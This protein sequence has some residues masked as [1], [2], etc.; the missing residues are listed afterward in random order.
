MSRSI[1]ISG[2]Y[3]N[4][5][6]NTMSKKISGQL[7]EDFLIHV[8]DLEILPNDGMYKHYKIIGHC[9]EEKILNVTMIKPNISMIRNAVR[10]I[11]EY[12]VTK[13]DL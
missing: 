7:D 3:K 8:F 11:N 5:K 1:T 4:G 9:Y 10:F 13:N 6:K 2:V 12:E